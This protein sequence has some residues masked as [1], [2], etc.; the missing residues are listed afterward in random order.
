M[1]NKSEVR[2]RQINVRVTPAE[3]AAIVEAARAENRRTG[4]YILTAALERAKRGEHD[5]R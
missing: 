3:L 1:K 4:N 2:S 5:Q